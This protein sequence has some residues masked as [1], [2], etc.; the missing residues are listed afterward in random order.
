MTDN[1][2]KAF[3]FHFHFIF[4]LSVVQ[5][6]FSHKERSKTMIKEARMVKKSKLDR[7][8]RRDPLDETS[9]GFHLLFQVREAEWG[10]LKRA[11]RSFPE[12][13][14]AQRWEYSPP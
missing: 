4:V 6:L 3:L 13:F 2:E 5:A 14:L 8:G 10:T 11:V 9:D 12:L 7:T 1:R